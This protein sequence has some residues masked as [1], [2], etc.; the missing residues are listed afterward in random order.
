MCPHTGI[1]EFT[2]IT[3]PKTYP[4]SW[5]ID[6]GRGEAG[7][8][9]D[10]EGEPRLQAHVTKDADL[11]VATPIDP[12]FML[13]PAV[14]GP[15]KAKSGNE[16]KRLFLSSD[17]HFDT[18]SESSPHLAEVLKCDTTRALFERRLEAICDTVEAGDEK[19]FRLSE[20]KVVDLMLS[21]SRAMSVGG[22]PPSLEEK[23]VA[24][25]LEAP[26]LVQRSSA[27]PVAEAK[28]VAEA[29]SAD[30]PSTPTTESA[31]SQTSSTT[32]DAASSFAS[33][34]ST[35][36]TSVDSEPIEGG[37]MSSM[38]AS[39]IV[40]ELQRLQV[41]FSFICATYVAQPIAAQLQELLKEQT[42]FGVDFAPL[43]TYLGELA[44]ARAEAASSRSM[45]DYSR[46]RQLDDEEEEARAEKKRK[47]EE[48]KK[49][50]ANESRGVKNLKK[51]N[52]TGMKKMSD[53]F[54]KK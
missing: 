21:K 38:T 28:R 14:F 22:L 27:I 8:Q 11:F 13:I 19:M 39:E 46:K 35:M 26:L 47:V 44:K 53:F 16:S 33:E 45:A 49:R 40:V 24:K 6:D 25:A 17:D 3:A 20:K 18:I 12:V 5:L 36:A 29:A 32:L 42:V 41:A 34:A 31:E 52:T 51:V 4:R 43:T 15:A 48:E 50:K 23:F 7:E 37:V 54:K 2:K 10:N 30:Q 1:Y 9:V